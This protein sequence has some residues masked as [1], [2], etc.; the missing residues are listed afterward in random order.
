M[1]S[2]STETQGLETFRVCEISAET[3]L[4][5]ASLGMLLNN[6]IEGLCP[7][8]S[9]QI[10]NRKYIR[11]NISSQIPLRQYFMDKVNKRRFLTVLQNVLSAIENIEDYMLDPEM[12][13]LDENEIY[14]NVGTL[15]TDLIYYPF[16]YKEKKLDLRYFVKSLIMNTEF[17]SNEQD[18][19]VTLLISYL[20][21]TEKL[22]VTELKNYTVSL[23]KGAPVEI[24]KQ[25][26]EQPYVTPQPI[27]AHSQVQPT[28]PQPI[29]EP[30][31]QTPQIQK[32][33][34]EPYR[35][36]VVQ[37]PTPVSDAMM[38]KDSKKKKGIFS[39]WDSKPQKEKPL[40]RAKADKKSKKEKS[41]SIPIAP[42]MAIPGRD[43]GE[44][45]AMPQALKAATAPNMQ[46][47]V[48]GAPMSSVSAQPYM[49][50]Q[51]VMPQQSATVPYANAGAGNF[52]ET[53]VLG[54]D[55]AGATTVLSSVNNATQSQ[56][57]P[58]LIRRKTNEKVEINK[59]LF[60]IGK[61]RGYVDYCISDNS[62]VSRSHADIHKKED[63]FYI[64][65]NNSLN[66]TFLN[67]K[68]IPS[69]QLQKLEDYMV[70]K[71]ADEVFEFRL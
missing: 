5:T 13:L 70:I 63:G 20:N 40:K 36:P 55:N 53:V 23:L 48:M 38:A 65:D 42:G 19:Y 15:R 4:D 28:M 58:Y 68:Q 37:N 25:P 59:N 60:R 41:T 43:N 10:D 69:S 3:Q 22:S 57:N 45:I 67:T 11:Y 47:P 71:L 61:E 50:A 39:L 64:I 49:S 31:Q 62:A 24:Q 7:V 51:P 46:Q 52:G 29:P 35:G 9:I 33:S 18:N 14:V 66:H 26:E 1:Y 2:F 21:R 17:D 8:S 44:N 56:R 12:L 32:M 6:K 34:Q 16:I 30:V 54:A 27:V